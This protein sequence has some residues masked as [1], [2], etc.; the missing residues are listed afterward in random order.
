MPRFLLPLLLLPLALAAPAT[1]TAADGK[2]LYAT[3]CVACHGAN[4]KSAIPGVA[5]L[6]TSMAKSDVQLIASILNGYQSKGSP[7]AM[8]PKGGN[9][10][11]TDAD[12]A[13]LVVYLRTLV[14]P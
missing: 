2:A 6:G 5:D 8:P 7:M 9:P 4:G 10:T 12:A 11:L 3:T 13:A 14:K 1:G